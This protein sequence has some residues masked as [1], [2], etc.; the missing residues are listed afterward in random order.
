VLAQATFWALFI[1]SLAGGIWSLLIVGNLAT[2]PTIPWA[3][4]VMAVVL[5][6]GW[7]YLGGAWWPSGTAAAR[8]RYL[9]ARAVSGQTF[10]W[11]LVAGVLS[12]GA[13]TGYWIVMFG[14]VKMPGNALT[15]LSNPDLSRYSTLVVVLA[16]VMGSL[17][18]PLSE[19]ASFRGYGLVILERAFPRSAAIIISSVLFAIPHIPV[20]GL[21][22]PKL[23]VYFL[24]GVTFAL[25]ADLSN[26]ILPAIPVHIL[27]DATFF[28]L[29]WPFDST[30][31]VIG[32]AG[33]DSWFW[34]HLAQAIV[35]TALAFLAFR[36]LARI[37]TR[38]GKGTAAPEVSL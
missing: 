38:G 4:G 10:A 13:L 19:E 24:A 28:T 5:W 33:P 12:L 14:L 32:E 3:V 6:L 25:I 17:V 23:F 11:A 8:R 18:S 2:T 35:F 7:R 9:R 1:S 26:S 31:V 16:I 34:I 36:R 27:G 15:P 21:W 22:L 29:V 20:A 30:R 37:S